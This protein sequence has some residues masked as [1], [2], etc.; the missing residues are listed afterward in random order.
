MFADEGGIFGYNMIN[1]FLVSKF[2]F[3]R[4]LSEFICVAHAIHNTK[5]DNEDIP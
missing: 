2:V 3:L 1:I 4:Y 5:Y